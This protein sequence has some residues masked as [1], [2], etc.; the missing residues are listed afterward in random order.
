MGD[1]RERNEGEH[2]GGFDRRRFLK[3]LG[4]G[5]VAGAVPGILTGGSWI[6]DAASLPRNVALPA[7]RGLKKVPRG[8]TLVFGITGG[9]MT[10]ATFINPFL[11]G[12][13]TATGFPYYFEASMYYNSYHT[14]KVSGPPQM[15]S[16]KGIIPW[17]VES[18][19]FPSPYTKL[20]MK[21]RQGV[22]WSDGQPFTSAD[23]A[24]TLNML[25]S[26][27]PKLTWS[28]DMQTWLKSV[29]TPDPQTVVIN[30]NTP[31]PRFMFDYFQ[32][33]QD[34]GIHIMPQHVWQ[35]QDPT[36]YT[37][38]DIAKGQPV[39]TSPW[40]LV[41]S[42]PTQRIFDRRSNWWASKLGFHDMPDAERIIVLPGTDE[43]NMVEFADA[44]QTDETI[45]LRPVNIQTVLAKNP[46]I[47]TWTGDKVPYGYRDWWPVS[48]GF[49]DSKPPFD[50]PQIRWA[51]NHTI[52]RDQLV[53]IGYH[54]AGEKTLLPYPNFPALEKYL[55]E[56][57]SLSAK[58]DDYDLKKTNS[59]MKGKGYKKN[60]SGL[61]EKDGKTVSML[62]LS[63][64]LFTDITPVLVEQLRKGGFDASF[65]IPA[66]TTF[67]QKVFTGEMDAF[68]NGHGGSVEEPYDTLKLYHS[69]YSAPTGQQ[70]TQPY[71][72]KDPKFDAIVDQMA[73]VP[74]DDFAQ[75]SS[76]FKKA[77]DIWVPA[78]PDIGLVQWFHRI[79]TNTT[80]WTNWSSAKNPYINTCYWHR[81]SPLWI[82]SI[83]SKSKKG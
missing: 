78:L 17:Q 83:K 47:T 26:N 8:K 33:H 13:S 14:S 80:H 39:T 27:A 82:Y 24:F 22:T 36:T 41:L 49:N 65:Q 5:G 21:I 40:E 28:T 23:Y 70:A 75:L 55:K 10:D 74:P 46:A 7:A 9:P 60:N 31:N 58:I 67:T 57:K 44:N 61:W 50:D 2:R 18:Y 19:Q 71:R 56:V 38:L 32:F 34:I 1:E 76:L 77:M 53:S 45:D 81:T 12:T 48:L 52:K 4:A 66:G 69:R 43:T 20:Q 25:K 79:P 35:G 15:K 29:E 59:I 72:W 6:A 73:Q 37:F 63:Q 11:T 16:S 54:G 62:I 51:V 42:T 3:L 64:I 68:M 30:L